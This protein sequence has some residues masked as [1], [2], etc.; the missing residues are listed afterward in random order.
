MKVSRI[1]I[2]NV[3]GVE[4]LQFET[5]AFTVV[6]GGNEAGKTSVL[7]AVKSVT[8][9]GKDATLLRKGAERGEVVLILEDGQRVSNTLGVG[10]GRAIVDP[11]LGALPSPAKL[12]QKLFSKDS[13]N[14]VSFLTAKK[15][16]RARL[17]LSA[18]PLKLEP[19]EAR[20][21]V[22][23]C[24]G[25][26]PFDA[27][28][29]VLLDAIKEDLYAQRTV[30]NRDHKTKV[31]TIKEMTE[32]LPPASDEP[33]TE[34]LNSLSMQLT[35]LTNESIDRHGKIIAEANAAI[36][37]AKT[38][39]RNVVRSI[40]A[41]CQAKIDAIKAE[42]ATSLSFANNEN[43]KAI[44]RAR[45]NSLAKTEAL[46]SEIQPQRAAL[47]QEIA[48]A[49]ERHEAELR[50]SGARDLIAGMDAEAETLK[51]RSDRL[52]ELLDGSI[53]KI[54]NRL[55]SQI[56]IP[57]IEVKDGDI[58][59]DD[60]PFDR[61]NTARRVSIAGRIAQMHAGEVPFIIVDGFEA[62]DLET[63]DAFRQMVIENNFQCLVGLVNPAGGNLEVRTECGI[64]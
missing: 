60:V 59:V 34:R 19:E 25:K 5:G 16:E 52:T 7:E 33:W 56:P 39:N 12:I 26:I 61:V 51:E 3:M 15:D 36:E 57:G 31:A 8:E 53:T 20:E 64:G 48:I 30:V 29:L 4:E 21:L 43:Q 63:Q 54:K 37:A 46:T 58:F 1:L 42:A 40:E 28:A 11:K 55:L 22:R 27:H 13:V 17:F 41:D 24:V 18:M 32:A 6:S 14:A 44:E 23:E 62:L 45:S 10:A 2:K 47:I 49:K 9:G 35:E 38:N 50:A